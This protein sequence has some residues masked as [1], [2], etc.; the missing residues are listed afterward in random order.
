MHISCREIRTGVLALALGGLLAG[1][2]GSGSG[3]LRIYFGLTGKGT[4]RSVSVNVDLAAASAVLAR[5]PDGA[6]DCVLASVLEADGCDLEVI[7][8][9]DGETLTAIITGCTIDSTASLFQCGFTEADITALSDTSDGT[10]ECK[11]P[12]CDTQP[13]VCAGQDSDPTSCEDCDNGKD[14][15]GNHLTDCDDSNCRHAPACEEVVPTTTATTPSDTFDTLP[16]TTTTTTM[17]TTTT[18]TTLPIES[19]SV[20]FRLTSDVTLGALQ[21]TTDY[22][23]SGG[24]FVGLGSQV[25]CVSLAAGAIPAFNDADAGKTLTAGL[26][27]IAGIDGPTDVVECSFQSSG[28]ATPAQFQIQVTEASDTDLNDIVP[29]P[30]I[31]VS[32]VNCGFAEAAS[33]VSDASATT[34]VASKKAP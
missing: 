13:P 27:S 18:S 30:E 31:V 10:C 29:T 17:T 6:V 4:C 26:I 19:C 16:P 24:E 33:I 9:E 23:A 32:S 22:A 14:D 15:D 25:E 1:C 12:D 2:S 20:V 5:L 34:P 8:S 7:E 28:Q 3:V 21:W 11:S